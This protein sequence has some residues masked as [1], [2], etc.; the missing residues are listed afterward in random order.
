MLS[1]DL[2]R[3]EPDRVRTALANRGQDGALVDRFL[4]LDGER[5]ALLVVQEDRKRQRNEA[6]REIGRL[7]ASG[8]DAAAAI[9]AVAWLKGEIEAAEARLAA[10]DEELAAVELSLPNLPHES[11]PV[12]PDA[13]ANRVEAVVGEPPRFAFPPQAHWDLGP[14]LGILDFERGAKVA[15][16]RFTTY[17]G[18]GAQLERALVN[19]MLDLHTREHGYTEVLPPFVV[20]RD[21]LVGTGQLPKFE[22]DLFHLDGFPYYLVPTAEVPVTNLHRDEVLEAGALPVRYCAYTPCFRSEAGSHGRDVRGL[23]RQHQ[24]NKVELVQLA[25]PETGLA[26]LEEMTGHARRVLDLLG[27]PYRVV[28][29]ATGDLGF[30]ATKTYDLEVWLPGQEAYREISSC[31][32]C[33][34]FQARRAN[35]RYRPADGGKP[36]LL[37]SLNGSGLAVGRTLIAI[38]ENCQQADGSIVIPEPLRPY[39]GGRDRIAPN[40]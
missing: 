20:N 39:L 2:L 28:T 36:R 33:S 4:A 29:L 26:Q 40:A 8:G 5:R 32:L 25:T 19:F 30:A 35:L 10:L 1:R 15:G 7:K 17:F 18:P 24:F 31:S 3:N 38:L 27:L 16:A 13:S 22:Q 14:A 6:S 12:G 23:I 11:L 21:S 9:G 37:H 34:D